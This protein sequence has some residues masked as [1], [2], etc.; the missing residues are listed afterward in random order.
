MLEKLLLVLSS[1]ICMV[2][3][4]TFNSLI[5][6]E[7]V[8]VYGV[9]VIQCYSFTCSHLVFPAPCWSIPISVLKK[10]CLDVASFPLESIIFIF[11]MNYVPAADLGRT[12][13]CFKFTLVVSVLHSSNTSC[14]PTTSGHWIACWG[15]HKERNTWSWPCGAYSIRVRDRH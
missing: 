12:C 15:D 1:R 9:K 5:H 7:S 8:F 10:Q 2:S 3:G 4:L 6:S 14:I 11:I 13:W